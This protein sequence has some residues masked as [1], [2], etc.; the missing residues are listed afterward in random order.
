MGLE[1]G[2]T[3]YDLGNAETRRLAA[4][5]EMWGLPMGKW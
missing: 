3:D 4:W 2:H 5:R 1:Y